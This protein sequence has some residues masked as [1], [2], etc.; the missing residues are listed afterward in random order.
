MRV[1][2][3]VCVCI[4]YE[5]IY[6]LETNSYIR[7]IYNA[8]GHVPVWALWL[9]IF[10]VGCCADEFLKYFKFHKYFS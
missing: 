6:S 2:V 5:N 10:F 8:V 9:E 7:F 3:C 1:C 4:I